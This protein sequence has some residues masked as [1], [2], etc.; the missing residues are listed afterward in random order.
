MAAPRSPDASRWPTILLIVGAGVVSAFQLGKA[1]M[2]LAAVQADLA[3]GLATVSWLLSAFA[4]VG[5]LAGIAVGVAVDHVGARRMALAGL[6]LQGAGSTIGALA[7][8][9][10]LLLAARAVEGLGFLAVAVAAPTLIVAVAPPRDRGRAIALW[11]TFIPVGMTVVMLG[12]PLLAVVGWRGYWLANA[13]VL[14][15]YA[16]LLAYGTR[17]I[18]PGAGRHRS[19][20]DDVRQTLAARGPWLLAG[21]FAAFSAAFFAVF[22]FL[23]SILSERLA[24]GPETGSVLAAAAVVVNVTGNLACGSLL[25]RGVRPPNILLAGF[26]T[27]ALCGFGILGDGVPGALAYALCL[28]FSAASGLVPVAL[29]DG[30]PRHAPRP[31]LVGATMG[32]L[33]QGNNVGLVVGPAAAGPLAAAFGWSAVAAFVAAVAVAASLLAVA[34]RDRPP[35]RAAALP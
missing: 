29:F 10:P 18:S 3:V 33:M 31:E 19:V 22:G 24:V 25:A 23:P 7:G 14:M 1:P 12:A 15:G 27:M 9:A 16:V 17:E 21:L 34:L 2:A 35:K 8:G 28:V 26:L 32:F 5:S 30:A 4:V 20:A 13:A 11:A 6:L